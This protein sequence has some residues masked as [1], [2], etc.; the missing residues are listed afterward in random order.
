MAVVVVA[1]FDVNEDRINDFKSAAYDAVCTTN[2]E[3]GCIVYNLHQGINPG[4]TTKIKTR[5][6][7]LEKWKS[8][9]DLEEHQKSDH[10]AAFGKK[11]ESLNFFTSQPNVYILNDGI[12]NVSNNDID[13]NPSSVRNTL[14]KM[15]LRDDEIDEYLGL[16]YPL[17]IGTN[18]FKGCY[19][20]NVHQPLKQRDLFLFEKW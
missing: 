15:D 16:L 18:Q 10:F 7:M 9:N 17:A 12:F 6:A 11:A 13:R 19:V 14:I 2:R 5:F 3:R 1:L 20:W 4:K 8:I